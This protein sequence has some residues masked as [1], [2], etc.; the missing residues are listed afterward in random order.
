MDNSVIS[1]PRYNN[2][3]FKSCQ[4]ELDAAVTRGI[5]PAKLEAFLISFYSEQ[6]KIINPND[7]QR[8]TMG[9]L[10]K[11]ILRPRQ[12]LYL[13]ILYNWIKHLFIP[14]LDPSVTENLLIFGVGRIFSAYSNIGVQYCTDADLNFVV[15]DSVNKSDVVKLT[16]EVKKLKQRIWDLFGIIVEVDA[17]FTVLTV[18]DIKARLEHPELDTRMAATLFYKGNAESL[19]VL[20]DNPELR[21]AVFSGVCDLPDTLLFDNFLGNNPFKTTYWRLREDQVQLSIISDATRQKEVVSMLIGTK[22]FVHNCRR[23]ASFHP[24]LYPPKW[25]FSMKYTVNRIYD[26]VSAMVHS[27]Y[28]VKELGF[29]G[30]ADPDYTF[31]CQ[32]HKLMLFLQ[33]LIHVRLDT[34]NNFSDYS[35]ISAERFDDFMSTPKGSFRSDFDEIVLSAHFLFASQK[36]HYLNLKQ[37]IHK[38][39]LVQ[40]SLTSETSEELSRQFGFTFRHIDK[41]SGKTPVAV[42]YSWSGLGF[43]VFSA[44]ETRLTAIVDTKLI[45]ALHAG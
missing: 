44:V 1:K 43:F 12:D 20:F 22:T 24:E 42:P 38:K 4:D 3:N 31:L 35:Y 33:E 39:Q 21:Q 23:L 29:T 41:G 6:H 18:R 17:A 40:L 2:K 25:W 14:G 5:A 26:Y 45:P 30:T 16:S 10:E 19:F 32:S 8:V 37:A 11:N 13:F 7:I 27:G 34:Y 36:K 15:T 28:T 9:T